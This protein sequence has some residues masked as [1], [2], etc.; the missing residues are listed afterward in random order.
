MEKAHVQ[1]VETQMGE[2]RRRGTREQR[3]AQSVDRR[4]QE[5]ARLHEQ[6]QIEEAA[7]RARIAALPP[8]ERKAMIVGGGPSRLRLAALLGLAAT[9]API[10]IVDRKEGPD[11]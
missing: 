11:A 6:H 5:E 8:E 2:A 4:K 7:R 10:L 1:R 3:I 9:A